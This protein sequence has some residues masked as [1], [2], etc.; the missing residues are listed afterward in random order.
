MTGHTPKN[1]FMGHIKPA[2]HCAKQSETTW[3]Y[4]LCMRIYTL[5]EKN[6]RGDKENK[7][8]GKSC[9]FD[10]SSTSSD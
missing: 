10:N 4:F 3:P 8:F 9:E 7:K 5:N 2:F 6:E 1:A